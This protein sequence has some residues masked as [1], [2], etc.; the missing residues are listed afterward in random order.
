MVPSLLWLVLKSAAILYSK[1]KMAL[2]ADGGEIPRV[3][4]AVRFSY[5]D[6]KAV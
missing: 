2:Q 6:K 3:L 5:Y 1:G 4:R